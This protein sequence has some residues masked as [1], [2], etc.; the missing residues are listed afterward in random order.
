MYAKRTKKIGT[1]FLIAVALTCLLAGCTSKSASFTFA[2]ATGEM[3]KVELDTMDGYS[4][5][6][7]EGRF[8]VENNGQ[9][10][11]GGLFITEETFD[12]YVALQDEPHITVLENDE[13]DTF[14]YYFYEYNDGSVVENNY[15][16]W[17]FDSNAGILIG[18]TSDAEITKAAFERLHF[19]LDE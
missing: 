2:L 6:Q 19:S 8:Y 7:D 14:S 17:V 18:G 15:L 12:E 9:Q 1:L 3:M 10:L 16:V 4:L 11:L 5:K 13:K